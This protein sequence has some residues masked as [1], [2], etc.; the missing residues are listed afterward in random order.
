MGNIAELIMLMY[1]VSKMLGFVI[2]ST[3]AFEKIRAIIHLYKSLILSILMC[4]SIW[5]IRYGSPYDQD[6]TKAIQHSTYFI[7]IWYRLS[8][9]ISSTR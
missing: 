2:R 1:N 7:Q 5:S 4:G 9:G 3:K 8:E 6:N